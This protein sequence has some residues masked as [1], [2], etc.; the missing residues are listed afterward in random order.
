MSEVPVVACSSRLTG[1]SLLPNGKDDSFT[2]TPKSSA[3]DVLQT[4]LILV[5]GVELE[6]GVGRSRL[7]YCRSNLCRLRS[8][9]AF[10]SIDLAPANELWSHQIS[11][12]RRRP[13]VEA[14][15]LT[16]GMLIIPLLQERAAFN[17]CHGF[18]DLLFF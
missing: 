6:A 4:S 9:R 15:S 3:R 1:I 12:S 7:H 14:L 5:K 17:T 2:P 8:Q 10:L 11:S 18:C 13:R 16:L